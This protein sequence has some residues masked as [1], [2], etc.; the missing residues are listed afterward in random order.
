VNSA[1]WDFNEARRN[2]H[3][4]SQRQEQAEDALRKAYIDKA[5]AEESFR[6]ALAN[7]ILELRDD[8]VPA[9]VCSDIARGDATVADLRRKRD[10]A[11]GVCEALSQAAWRMTADRKDAQR[12]ADWSQRR[13]M[14]ETGHMVAA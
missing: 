10:I 13:E 14:A 12:F 6:V 8:G 4:A 2:C 3:R 11:E 9:T 5:I 7:R 1:P